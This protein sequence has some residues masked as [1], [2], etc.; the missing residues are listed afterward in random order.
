VIVAEHPPAAAEGVGVEVVGLLMVAERV[1]VVGE[2]VA[3]VK[4]WGWSSPRTRRRLRVS[5]WRSWAC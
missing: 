4:V 5:V 1:Q 2:V 3:E